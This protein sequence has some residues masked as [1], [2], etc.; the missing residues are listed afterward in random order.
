MVVEATWSALR[1]MVA[2]RRPL[3]TASSMAAPTVSRITCPPSLVT[4]FTLSRSPPGVWAV[5]PPT[6]TSPGCNP[7][8]TGFPEAKVRVILSSVSSQSRR[9]PSSSSPS[10]LVVSGI[11]GGSYLAPREQCPPAFPRYSKY[12]A[13]SATTGAVLSTLVDTSVE[14]RP[15]SPSSWME[16]RV[17]AGRSN[18]WGARNAPAGAGR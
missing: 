4:L 14:E 16:E 9:S 18:S 5:T 11:T 7:S 1:G 13:R 15:G 3:S 10:T 6:I 12:M 2:S 17:P 8:M